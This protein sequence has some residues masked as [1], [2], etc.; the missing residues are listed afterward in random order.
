MILPS[1]IVIELNLILFPPLQDVRVPQDA[2]WLA[3]FQYA[4]DNVFMYVIFRILSSIY[5]NT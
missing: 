1:N 3:A 5:T 2:A 4:T